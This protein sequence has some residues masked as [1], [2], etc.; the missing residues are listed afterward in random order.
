MP[1]PDYLKVERREEMLRGLLVGL[2]VDAGDAE[3]VAAPHKPWPL[4]ANNIYHSGVA[5]RHEQLPFRGGRQ[6]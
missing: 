4:P 2:E 1:A 3:V 6:T 5:G